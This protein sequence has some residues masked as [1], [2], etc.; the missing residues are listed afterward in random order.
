MLDASCGLRPAVPVPRT[1][2]TLHGTDITLVGSDPSYARAVAFSI[3]RSHGV[4][5]VSESLKSDTI[6]SL[7]VRHEIRVIPNSLDCSEYRR[8]AD[9]ELRARVCP[10]ADCDALV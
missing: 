9:P 2:T 6:K 3:E 8:R 4:T 10:T 7:G 1:V 5:T